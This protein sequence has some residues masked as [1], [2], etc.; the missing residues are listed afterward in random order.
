MEDAKNEFHTKLQTAER[1]HRQKYDQLH[2]DMEEMRKEKDAKIRQLT[3][4]W[5]EQRDIYEKRINEMDL[6]I[7]SKHYIKLI[8]Y[9]TTTDNLGVELY[10]H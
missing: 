3:R 10:H 1:D 8:G 7:K 4:E 6:I 2:D 5:E 9:R